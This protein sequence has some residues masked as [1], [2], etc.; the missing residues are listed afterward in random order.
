MPQNAPEGLPPL[1]SDITRPVGSYHRWPCHRC[2]HTG[3]RSSVVCPHCEAL[4]WTVDRDA[5]ARPE[6]TR[7]AAGD[8][9]GWILKGGTELE[10]RSRGLLGN[11]HRFSTRTGFL[12][13]LRRRFT[14]GADWLGA[15]GHEWRIDR[16]GPLGKALFI[17]HDGAIPIAAGQSRGFW[18]GAY[19][20][21]QGSRTFTLMP[22]GMTRRN[23]LLAVEDG[24]E[25]LRLR[26]GIIQP[27]RGIEILTEL[28]VAS[29]VIAAFLA[30]RM[31]QGE[32]E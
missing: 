17:L 1:L 29:L 25:V 32:S 19:Q 15:D 9:A 13:V 18:R 7:A 8:I 30:C 20:V 6:D 11:E 3:R 22:T 31:R 16:I 26:G 4:P 24:P 10:I 2:G 14:S 12:G 21:W 23:Y 5:T 28:P 27:L